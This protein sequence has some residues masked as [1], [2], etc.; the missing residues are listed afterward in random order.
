MLSLHSS[1]PFHQIFAQFFNVAYSL[2]HV[3]DVVDASF[4]D[5]QPLGRFVYFND[6]GWG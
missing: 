1:D 4:L 6:L 3:G 5:G 2:Q